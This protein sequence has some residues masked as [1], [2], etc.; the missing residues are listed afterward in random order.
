MAIMEIIEKLTF[1]II[2][3]EEVRVVFCSVFPECRST[4]PHNSYRYPITHHTRCSFRPRASYTHLSSIQAYLFNFQFDYIVIRMNCVF[5]PSARAAI[6]CGASASASQRQSKSERMSTNSS[7]YV[8]FCTCHCNLSCAESTLC[9][10]QFIYIFCTIVRMCIGYNLQHKLPLTQT[11]AGVCSMCRGD[12][13]RHSVPIEKYDYCISNAV[14]MSILCVS[15]LLLSDSVS[16]CLC[17]M[18]CSLWKCQSKCKTSHMLPDTLRASSHVSDV[19][20]A[21]RMWMNYFCVHRVVCEELVYRLTC[22]LEL[23]NVWHRRR[24]FSVCFCLLRCATQYMISICFVELQWNGGVKLEIDLLLL[25][26]CDADT[27]SVFAVFNFWT[28]KICRQSRTP[29]SLILSMFRPLSH[30]LVLALV[31][32]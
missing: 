1:L 24:E 28:L 20:C 10:I 18:Q 7:F 16:V 14:S 15:A 17:E 27:S 21:S 13:K 19:V 31:P 9:H 26:L 29:L 11:A 30:P 23:A 22:E 8:P 6:A 3:R 5:L 25:L 4:L 32:F 2:T 12:E